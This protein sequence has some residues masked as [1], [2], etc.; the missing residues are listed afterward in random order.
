MCQE[1]PLGPDIHGMEAAG[2]LRV[3]LDDDLVDRA[4]PPG[5]AQVVTAGE[6]IAM[7]DSGRV[8]EL[9]L[10]HDLG[11]DELY[12][13]RNRRHRL[14]RRATGDPWAR[15]LAAGRDH[16]PHR[17][18]LRPR[19]DGALDPPLRDANSTPSASYQA[20]REAALL[21]RAREPAGHEA[22][23]ASRRRRH[24]GPLRARSGPELLDPGLQVDHRL[25]PH[26]SRPAGSGSQR[27]RG[28]FDLAWATSWEWEANEVSPP[29]S[30]CSELP[31]ARAAPR[32]SRS[33]PTASCPRFAGSWGAAV[34]L[35][36]RRDRS[37]RA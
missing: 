33:A 12:G 14:H 17:Q 23:A 32:T 30:G 37:R 21:L 1:P 24:P 29:C 19:R 13:Q 36:R 31:V 28:A 2:E 9:S 8:V 15:P 34:R 10:D 7:L 4:A 16:A 26:P 27:F 3:W 35:A 22:S 25:R 5:W 6:A 11:D 20:G 18:S